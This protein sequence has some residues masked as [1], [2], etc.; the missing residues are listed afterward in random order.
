M[1]P[2]PPTLGIWVPH[3]ITFV[4]GICPYQAQG[5]VLGVLMVPDVQ[6]HS[7]PREADHNGD[8]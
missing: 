5:L 1:T 8:A 3:S 2:C 7:P 6:E 4:L